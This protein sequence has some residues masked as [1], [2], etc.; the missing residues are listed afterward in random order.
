MKKSVYIAM[1]LLFVL[2]TLQVPAVQAQSGTK[3]T[4]IPLKWVDHFP[5]VAGGNIFVKKQYFP[6][7]QAQLAKIGYELDVTFYHSRLFIK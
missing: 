3:L 1:A 6:R 2:V 7:I 5:P 4:K